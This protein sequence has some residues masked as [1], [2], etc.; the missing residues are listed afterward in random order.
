MEQTLR[1]L[2]S[3]QTGMFLE[4]VSQI[5]GKDL[6]P[7]VKMDLSIEK[8]CLVGEL[9]WITEIG[10]VSELGHARETLGRK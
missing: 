1:M 9:N 2:V 10:S 8:V 4:P 5:V 7:T 3:I 6:V